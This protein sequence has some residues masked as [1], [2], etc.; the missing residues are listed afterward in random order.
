MMQDIKKQAHEQARLEEAELI[1]DWQHSQ[2]PK[3]LEKIFQNHKTIV[4]YMALGYRGYGLPIEDLKSEGYIG[5]MHALKH[6]DLSKG[7]RFHTYAYW[8]IK[9][10]INDYILAN[11]S[12]VKMV[13]NA[14]QKKLFFNLARM[15]HKYQ[16]MTPENI[17]KIAKELNVAESEVVYM[18]KRM[19]KDAS[20]HASV[21]SDDESEWIDFLEDKRQQPEQQALQED[22]LN[23][24]KKAIAKAMESLNRREYDIFTKRRIYDPPISLHELAKEYDISKERVRQIEHD[25]LEKIKRNVMYA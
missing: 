5:I 3:A 22:E 11:I 17:K 13:K 23:H 4:N 20:L 1:Q 6:F 25:A 10:M 24:R 8:W 19:Q 2:N 15:K 21:T 18:Q 16:T 12:M 9:A 7:F 14:D